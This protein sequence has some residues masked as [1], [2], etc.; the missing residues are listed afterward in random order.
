[1]DTDAQLTT[2]AIYLRNAHLPPG[3]YGFA[4]YRDG[5]VVGQGRFVKQ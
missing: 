5:A 3:L 2:D 1:V 4:L